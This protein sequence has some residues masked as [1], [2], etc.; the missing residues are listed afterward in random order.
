M[1][2]RRCPDLQG[3]PS[4]CLL[5]AEDSDY[6]PIPRGKERGLGSRQR[7]LRH[8]TAPCKDE[9]GSLFGDGTNLPC[10]KLCSYFVIV[11]Q[12]SVH[13]L[14]LGFWQPDYYCYHMA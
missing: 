4:P 6:G 2:G 5:G 12:Y 3:A 10:C 1:D 13:F 8:C 11:N 7:D 14:R 9:S